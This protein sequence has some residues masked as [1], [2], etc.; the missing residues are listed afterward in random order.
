MTSISV[1]AAR[2][3]QMRAAAREAQMR[4]AAREAQTRTGP[5]PV[6]PRAGA[7]DRLW[8]AALACLCC[9]LL[10]PLFVV[11]VPPLVDYPNHLARAFVL[12]ALPNDAALARFYAPHWSII[13]NLALDLILPPLIQLLPVHVAGRLLIAVAVLLPVLGT[14]AYN[15]A[16]NPRSEGRWWSLGVGLLAYNNCLLYGFLNFAIA[17][18]FALLLAAGWLRWRE[19]HPARAIT[20]ALLGA[21]ALFVCHLMG[22]VFFLLLIGAAD[23]VGLYRTRHAGLARAVLMRGAVLLLIIAVPSGLYWVSA[24][25]PLGGDAQFMPI[26]EKLLQLVTVFDNYAWQ[27]DRVA[28]VV[29]IAVAVLCLALRRGL[30][31]A[32]AACAMVLLVIAFL[33]APF[34]WKETYFLDTRFAVMLGFMLFAGFVP[35]NWP[36]SFRLI[37][38]AALVILFGAR[39]ALLTEVWTG[40]AADLADLRAVLAPVQPGQAVYVAE[41]GFEEAPFYWDANPNWRLLAGGVRADEHLGALVLIE[42]RAYWPFTFDNPS[43]QPI[44]TLEPYRT[45]A[46][47]VGRIPSRTEAA[48]ADVCGFDYV[49]LL[50]AGAVEGLPEARFQL[51]ARSGFA[52]LYAIVQCKAEP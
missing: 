4:A 2:E 35:V 39:I 34:A 43:Q 13:P 12:A 48:I 33:A 52:A 21:P 32:P 51:L 45:L 46:D 30:V 27:L 47:R 38:G 1:A 44:E 7:G 15:T 31:P 29:A 50:E 9:V 11:D 42:R 26:G 17:L 41:A 10:A 40:R 6:L 18:G 24:L 36:A 25:Q 16:V 20:L 19:A 3:A 23:L 28:A 14:I 8:W 49:L 22:L 5:R 37:I